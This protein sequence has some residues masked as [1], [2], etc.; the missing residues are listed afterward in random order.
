M[1]PPFSQRSPDHSGSL[2]NCI[3]RGGSK[4]VTA[5]FGIFTTLLPRTRR[6]QS[7]DPTREI[8]IDI[9]S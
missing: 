1:I 9:G 3:E 5:S 6:R 4:H 7:G 8:H 2:L